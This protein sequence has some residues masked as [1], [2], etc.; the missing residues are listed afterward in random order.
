M[1]VSAED[2]FRRGKGLENGMLYW[3][4]LC[5]IMAACE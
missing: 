1:A 5:A 2:D 4:K 3:L